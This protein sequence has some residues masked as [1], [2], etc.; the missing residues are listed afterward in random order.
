[1][2]WVEVTARTL[3]EAKEAA[4]DQ[5]GVAEE[6]AEFEIVEEP[7][8]GL[9]GRFR[10]EARVRARVLPTSPRPKAETRERRPRSK[11]ARSDGAK[12]GGAKNG[13]AKNGGTGGGASGGGSAT[14]GRASGPRRRGAASSDTESSGPTPR[15]A[16]QR[17][18]PEMSTDAATARDVPLAE[19]GEEAKAFLEGLLDAFGLDGDVEVRTIDEDTIEVVVEGEGLGPLV[20]HK[21]QTLQAVQEL[22]RTVV[23]R[24]LSA[25]NGRLL[26]DVAGYRAKRKTALE[27]FVRQVADE[28]RASGVA[29][30]LE[31]MPPPDRKVI[32]DAAT[33]LEG[34]TTESEG[35]EPNRRVVIMPA[36]TD[37]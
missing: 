2:E 10:S 33:E 14:S 26:V 23:Q 21:G 28:V 32:H 16:K 19:Q 6:E 11:A 35:E 9:F 5:L 12:N 13:G 27:A 18:A 15:S 22:A 4:L 20:G 31:P 8:P 34:V 7:R 17:K 30:V 24:R 37:A 36:S 1:M 29:K 3:E 25:H